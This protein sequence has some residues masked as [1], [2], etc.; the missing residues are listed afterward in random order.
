[1]PYSPNYC[2]EAEVRTGTG[3]N[4]AANI[5]T[6]TV[7]QYITM[8]TSVINSI[9]G[10]TYALPID[11][12]VVFCALLNN[13][14][15]QMT[16]ALLY[17]NEYGEDSQDNSGKSW[18]DRYTLAERICNDIRLLKKRLFDAE[19]NE[20]ERNDDRVPS[21]YPTAASS[22]PNAP[23]TTKPQITMDQIY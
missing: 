20:L 14:A 12:D 16:T 17:M 7:T 4:D 11:M 23:C 2:T 1:M 19:G 6:G 21:F 18:K 5:T 10:S 15:I 3:F 13:V 9:I 8:T 22:D